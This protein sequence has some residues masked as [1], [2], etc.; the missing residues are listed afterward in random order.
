MRR[1]QWFKERQSEKQVV[2]MKH[3]QQV[4]ASPARFDPVVMTEKAIKDAQDFL[5]LNK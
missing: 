4:T 5:Q 1:E 2:A 3:S